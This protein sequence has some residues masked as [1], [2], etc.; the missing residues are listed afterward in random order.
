MPR[1]I[2]IRTT[3]RL[4]AFV[5]SAFAIC[6]AGA[7]AAEAASV[8][9]DGT[10][11]PNFFDPNRRL[12]RPAPGSI[13]SIRFTTTDDFPPF[14][15]SGPDGQPAGFNV[16]LARAICVELAVP[17]T[18]QVRPFDGLLDTVAAGRVDAAIAGIAISPASRAKIEFSDV[19]LRPAARFVARRGEAPAAIS[20]EGLTGKTIA[21]VKGSAHEAYLAAFFPKAERT[22]FDKAADMEAALKAGKADLA[23]GDGGQLAFWLQ[24]ATAGG[25]CGFAGGPYL[26]PGF[27]GEGL[28]IALPPGRTDLR[29]AINWALDSLSDKGAL[30]EL[31]LRYF[32]VGYF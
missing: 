16:D 29:Q 24:S 1:R 8:G 23:F 21:V 20:P 11:I 15:F 4:A 10:P 32:P 22:L 7:P 5:L 9:G 25:C 3:S 17:C 12:D 19:Y 26:D 30:A 28:A 18:I 6:L 14:S 2:A 13:G 31:Y 27:F